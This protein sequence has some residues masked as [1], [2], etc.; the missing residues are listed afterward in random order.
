MPKRR[1]FTNEQKE[2]ILEAERKASK[3][4]E[5]KRI[6]ILRL[7]AID[8]MK[9]PEVAKVVGYNSDSV[10]NIVAKYFKEGIDSM[11]GENRKGGNKRYLS[12]EENSEFLKIF[13]EKAEKGQMLIVTEIKKEYEKKIG[14]EVP[15]ST[16]YRILARQKWRKVMPRS[17]HPKS[18]PEEQEAYKKNK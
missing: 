2:E 16:I 17:K 11:L 12:E 4:F 18:K 8:N 13:E 9:T 14:K 1:E 5:T 7:I 10:N 15:N 6:M 3:K